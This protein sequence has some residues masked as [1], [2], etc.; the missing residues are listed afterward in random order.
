MKRPEQKLESFA[1]RSADIV[2]VKA[3]GNI[4]NQ[5][6]DGD[7]QTTIYQVHYQYLIKQKG[8]LYQEEEVEVRMC[9]FFKSDLI[10]DE[11]V[12]PYAKQPDSEILE[13]DDQE[14]GTDQLSV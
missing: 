14:G 4:I 10:M 12:N 1:K 7:F 2:K 9:K 5:S 13:I 3:R 8:T 11:E 6:V